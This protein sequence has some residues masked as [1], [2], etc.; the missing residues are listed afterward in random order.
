VFTSGRLTT[1]QLGYISE[2]GFGSVLSISNFINED[3][4]YNDVAGKW[5]STT[6][7]A[8]V[9]AK[10]GTPFQ[11]MV[12][13]M[14]I[15]SYNEFFK[16]M[17][18]MPKP[19]VVQSQDGWMASLYADLYMSQVGASDI[20]D[21][22][23]ISLTQG[24]DYQSDKDAV[25]LINAVSGLAAEVVPASIDLTLSNGE[26]SYAAYYWPH[27]LGSDNWYTL[28]QILET[29]V[30]AIQKAGYKTVISFRADGEGTNRLSWEPTT[31]PVENGEFSDAQGLYNVT[32]EQ[33]SV[34]DA[35]MKFYNLPV[36]GDLAFTKEQYESF[37][38]MFEEAAANGPVL[39]HCASG[40]RSSVYALAFMAR[41]APEERC[42]DWAITEA[43]RIGE[44]VDLLESDQKAIDFWKSTLAC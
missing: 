32:A 30:P 15:D 43:R 10:Y 35:G 40:Y 26:E 37:I 42:L 9:L 36:S 38:P 17:V 12:A 41:E 3:T 11:T 7:E 33:L 20:T 28:G 5:P 34:T 21:I 23:D 6:Q 14:T 13:D 27:R 29:Q 24:F 39:V 22:F 16:T 18:S 2:V 8:D 1:R 31:G 44:S 19:V 25:S 4:E